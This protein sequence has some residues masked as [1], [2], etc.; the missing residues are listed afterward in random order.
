MTNTNNTSTAP[1][2]LVLYGFSGL[3]ALAYE[4]LWIRMLSLQ[5]GVSN[6]GVVITV[7]AFMLGL[8]IGS[9][10]GNKLV[11]SMSRPLRVFAF[12]ELGIALYAVALPSISA[13]TSQWLLA[14]GTGTSLFAWHSVEMM[15]ALCFMLLPALAMGIGFPIILTVSRRYSISIASLYGANTVGAALGAVLPILLLP[16][17]GWSNSLL[18]VAFIGSVVGLSL[19]YLSGSIVLSTQSQQ[20]VTAVKPALIGLLC[21]SLIGAAALALQVTWTRLYGMVLLRTEYVL[22]IIL[23]IFLVGIALGSAM[24]KFGKAQTWLNLLPIVVAVAALASLASLSMISN[25]VS[26]LEYTS[27]SSVIF[28]Q[29]SLLALATLTVTFCLGAW[30]PLLSSLQ[31]NSSVA[32]AWYYGVNAIGSG[33]GALLA[34]FILMPV[35]GSELTIVLAMA[36]LFAASMFWSQWRAAWLALPVLLVFSLASPLTQQL[37]NELPATHVGSTATLSLHEDAIAVTHVVETID[38]QRLLL[39]DLQ[40]MDA[41]TEPSAVVAQQNQARLPLLLH[42]DPKTALFLGLGTG[43]SA[44]AALDFDAEVTAVELSQGAIR[45]AQ[46][47]FSPVNRGV[48]ERIEVIHDDARRYLMRSDQTYDV[49]IGDLFH[50]DLVGRSRLLSLQQFQRVA[51]HLNNDGI[52]VQ[53]LA[54]NQFD[55]AALKVVLNSFRQVFPQAALFVDGF[56]VAMVGR[57]DSVIDAQGLLALDDSDVAKT[58]N[59]G[60]WTWLGRYYGLI[61]DIDGRVEDEWRPQIEYHLPR[62]RYS[63]GIDL[64]EIVKWLLDNRPT[65]AQA[66]RELAISAVDQQQFER[67]Y[68]SADAALRSWQAQ[69]GGDSQRAQRFLQF[70]YQGNP[71]DQWVSSTV[72]DNMLASMTRAPVKS[73]LERQSLRQILAVKPDHV[74]TLEAL[75]KLAYE[76]DNVGEAKEYLDKI[77]VLSPLY[78]P[79]IGAAGLLGEQINQL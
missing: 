8:G 47:W 50:P 72:A 38:G 17:L 67:A 7:S 55:S 66:A 54:L 4:V 11:A 73:E 74:P 78:R 21:Y 37:A 6:F 60:K 41:S 42:A 64:Q 52:Y 44:S 75:A 36:V 46:D 20:T 10:L 30:L 3:V 31:P 27:F 2:L 15:A 16:A 62:V 69:L 76:E 58:G 59:E 65:P 32:G 48:M 57:V 45:S 5:F 28:T 71:K 34:G 39:S 70:A 18:L 63:G 14:S 19:W 1:A 13:L 79:R 25:T 61:P 33:I 26:N 56:R 23:A 35:L 24:S 9:V 12:I 53:W 51:S 43:I 40:R 29:S 49:V 77:K 68:L 22:A